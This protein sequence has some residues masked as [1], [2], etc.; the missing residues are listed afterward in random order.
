MAGF[1]V[2]GQNR[3]RLPTVWEDYL[4]QPHCMLRENRTYLRVGRG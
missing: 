3:S 4:D 1:A 2:R